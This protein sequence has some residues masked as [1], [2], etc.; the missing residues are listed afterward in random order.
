MKTNNFYIK[1]I[2]LILILG[3]S[4]VS[5]SQDKKAKRE[6]R[7]DRVKNLKIAYFTKELN[8]STSESEKFW[9]IYNEMEEKIKNIRKSSK[10]SIDQLKDNSE[11]MSDDDFKKSMNQIFDAEIEETNVKKESYNKIAGAIGYKKAGKVYKLEREFKVMLI[12]E[13]KAGSK[14]SKQQ[15]PPHQE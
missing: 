3:M 14:G 9:P 11:M 10:K 1:N 8:L 4:F 12:N 13:M 5:F 6:E 7:Q 2:L 15:R